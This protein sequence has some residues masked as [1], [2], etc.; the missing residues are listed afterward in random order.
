MYSFNSGTINALSPRLVKINILA[1]IPRIY[2][3]FS[4]KTLHLLRDIYIFHLCLSAVYS[5]YHEFK[6]KYSGF[7]EPLRYISDVM[8][9]NA[10]IL[11][12][13]FNK[14][15]LHRLGI[16]LACGPQPKNK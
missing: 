7:S 6:Q 12:C 3:S 14:I 4:K 11:V 13:T 15:I 8:K 10:S 2:M 16:Y 1:T 9:Y 5:N